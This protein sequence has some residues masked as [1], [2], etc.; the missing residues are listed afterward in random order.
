M[1]INKSIFCI[2]LVLFHSFSCYNYSNTIFHFY[3]STHGDFSY[4]RKYDMDRDFLSCFWFLK[5]EENIKVMTRDL[6]P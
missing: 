3:G 5:I 2:D 4:L 6:S 1:K